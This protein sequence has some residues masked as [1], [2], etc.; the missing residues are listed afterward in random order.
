MLCASHNIKEIFLL[1]LIYSGFHSNG[2]LQLGIVQFYQ[3]FKHSD[4]VIDSCMDHHHFPDAIM[5][6]SCAKLLQEVCWLGKLWIFMCHNDSHCIHN[7]CHCYYYPLPS[8][9]G[10]GDSVGLAFSAGWFSSGNFLKIV[11]WVC[12]ANLNLSLQ[13]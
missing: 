5:C 2:P 3:Y 8:S 10:I 4:V 6:F 13:S 9:V 12:L 11:I 7:K 1:F